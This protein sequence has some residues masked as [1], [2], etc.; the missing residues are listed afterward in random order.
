MRPLSKAHWFNR[1]GHADAA[2]AVCALEA[3]RQ[4]D[5]LRI[6]R[7]DD[8]RLTVRISAG[9]TSVEPFFQV[10][11]GAP[12]EDIPAALRTLNR[13]LSPA[14]YR[15]LQVHRT[16]RE[17]VLLECVRALLDD[18]VEMAKALLRRM[19]DA[20]LGY[21]DLAVLMETHPKSLVR[22]LSRQGNPSA[23]NLIAILTRVAHANGARFTVQLAE[24]PDRGPGR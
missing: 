5:W 21:D 12:G 22:M 6:T 9:P 13:Q 23:R 16:F 2:R 19:T 4:Y 24:R 20:T 17:C 18:D 3:V 14:I 1:L 15:R 11:F 8:K 10:A 7:T